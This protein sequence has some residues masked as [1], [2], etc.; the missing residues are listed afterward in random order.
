MQVD[1]RSN[2]EEGREADFL[3]SESY[4]VI[5]DVLGYSLCMSTCVKVQ[6]FFF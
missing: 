5:K 4:N 2:T 6:V 1:E 3:L